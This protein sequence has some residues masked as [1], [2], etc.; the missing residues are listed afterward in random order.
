MW[1]LTGGWA[2]S[3]PVLNTVLYLCY[4][5]LIRKVVNQKAI[6]VVESHVQW[7]VI[8][9]AYSTIFLTNLCA[10]KC[11]LTSSFSITSHTYHTLQSSVIWF[12][13]DYVY[14]IVCCS[15]TFTLR[16]EKSTTKR[17][18][19]KGTYKQFMETTLKNPISKS[20]HFW[21]TIKYHTL[22]VFH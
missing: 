4:T 16:S 14:L 7:W 6:W 10:Q 5:Q 8:A 9:S 11:D 13:L 12:R 15:H 3:D 20:N 18:S 17:E 2:C 1:W 19:Y 22:I 21:V